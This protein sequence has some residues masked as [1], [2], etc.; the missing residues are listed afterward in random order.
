MRRFFLAALAVIVSAG[1]LAAAPAAD[2]TAPNATPL[3]HLV[4]YDPWSNYG[5]YGY[6][7]GYRPACP[8]YY[9]YA[10]WKDPHGFGHC[11][12]LLDNGRWWLW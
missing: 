12:C 8:S 3:R 4:Q 5:S 6:G 1:A 10:C 7:W 11:G 9:H 2:T